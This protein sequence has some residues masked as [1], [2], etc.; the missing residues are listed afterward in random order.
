MRIL[1]SGDGNVMDS[2]KLLI[3]LLSSNYQT[4]NI[5]WRD[6]NEQFMD[7]PNL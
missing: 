3:L 2:I 5:V 1:I 4:I 6:I 7:V